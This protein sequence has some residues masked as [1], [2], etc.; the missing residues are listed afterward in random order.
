LHLAL[1]FAGIAG[2]LLAQPEPA[3][4]Q[5]AV[6]ATVMSD[7]RLRGVSLSDRRPALT[8]GLSDD[9]SN[10]VYFGATAI[11][12]DAAGP[13]GHFLGHQEYLGYAQRLDNGMTWEAGLDNQHYEA[14]GPTPLRQTYTEAYFG[15]AA[16]RI[17]TRL[18]YSPNYNGSN[19]STAYFEANTAFR[20]ADGWRITGHAG[21]FQALNTWK[22]SP[23]KPRYDGRIDVI[24]R[25]GPAELSVGWAG[26][27]PPLGANGKLSAGGVI[28]GAAVFF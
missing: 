7:Y 16:G 3:R 17:S 4:A 21:I 25:I 8:L 15:L 19:H 20:P 13:H 6:A 23:R 10:G 5:V 1:A 18:Y 27:S 14:Y 26:A 28:V 11:L 12:Q 22:F 9:L 2:G 24:R